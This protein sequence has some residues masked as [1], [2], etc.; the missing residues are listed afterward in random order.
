LAISVTFRNAQIGHVRAQA[1]DL[2]AEITAPRIWQVHYPTQD[3]GVEVPVPESW[4]PTLR[5]IVDSLV[6]RDVVLGAGLASVDPVSVDDTQQFLRAVD[7][8]GDVTLISLP[9]E[10]WHTSVARWNGDRWSCLV[11]LWTQPEGRSDLVLEVDV[12][13]NG[14]EYRFC[15]H[16]VYVP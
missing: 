12:F 2:R 6:R 13:E 16:L 7:H 11:D 14:P 15:V 1:V 9:D 5:A 8:Y 4:R 3:E 10:T